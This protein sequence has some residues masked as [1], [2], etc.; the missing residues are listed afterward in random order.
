MRAPGIVA[1][2]PRC[3]PGP[4]LPLP[5]GQ[6]R[7]QVV[8]GAEFGGAGPGGGCRLRVLPERPQHRALDLEVLV[9][10]E[11]VLELLQPRDRALDGLLPV[12][13][14]EEF[15]QIAQ[16]LARLAQIVQGLGGARV[17]DR[18]PFGE[19]AVVDLE[20]A[21]R[22]QGRDRDEGVPAPRPHGRIALDER[23]ERRPYPT[24]A[25]RS[26][27][28]GQRPV[29]TLPG[30]FEIAAQRRKD[31]ALLHRVPDLSIVKGDGSQRQQMDV[32]ITDRPGALPEPAEVRPKPA[33]DA[34]REHVLHLPEQRTRLADRHPEIVQ[35]FGV[36]VGLDGG[37]VHRHHRVE[38]R[39]HPPARRVR[40]LAGVELRGARDRQA[41][42]GRPRPLG[43]REHGFFPVG[44]DALQVPQPAGRALGEAFVAA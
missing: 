13:A 10:A 42:E 32:Q 3:E 18:P 35:A 38:G 20:D 27:G 11:V 43:C 19:G 25:G 44:R 2:E 36:E 41:T 12:D 40:T 9:R 21:R 26:Q 34:R 1:G 39:Q 6:L 29:F 28:A 8:D 30:R 37:G 15:K 4:C 7:A 31:A 22:R 23:P 24:V 16:P 14:P 17:P 33:G 5:F